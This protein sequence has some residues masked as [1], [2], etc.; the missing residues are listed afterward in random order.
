MEPMT[1]SPPWR[2]TRDNDELARD[3]LALVWYQSHA[4]AAQVRRGSESANTIAD[5]LFSAGLLTLNKCL[6]AYERRRGLKFST[7]LT[8]AL[9]R[10]F[11]R[12]LQLTKSQRQRGQ[13]RFPGS[14]SGLDVDGCRHIDDDGVLFRKTL[15]ARDD[16]G[17]DFCPDHTEQKFRQA[18]RSLPRRDV[19][20]I[21]DRFVR[22]RHLH[23][24]GRSMGV[25]KTR[26]QQ[27]LRRALRTIKSFPALCE[28]VYE[29][30]EMQ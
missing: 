4:F 28:R 20:L 6:R 11:S 3:H 16:D 18:L 7:L 30:Q 27:L 17:G 10:E 23:Q 22:G 13:K 14:L 2:E 26:V 15:A 8:L 25:T 1:E 12:Q 21:V 29:L 24:I 9:K 5:E 19:D